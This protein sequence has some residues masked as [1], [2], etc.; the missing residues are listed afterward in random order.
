MPVSALQWKVLTTVSRIVSTARIAAR[1]PFVVRNWHTFLLS[2]FTHGESILRL[3]NG[4]KFAIRPNSS[5][6]ASI[7]EVFLLSG[8]SPVLPGSVVIDIGANIGAFS[9]FAAR[10]AKMIYSLEPVSNNFEALR[11]NVEM[12]Q[13]STVSIHRLAMA[14]NN[15]HATI[16]VAGVESSLYFQKPGSLT[17]LVQTVSLDR[18]LDDHDIAFVDYLKMDCEGAEWDILLNLPLHVFSRIKYIEL[19][20]HNIGSDTNVAVLQDRLA[21]ANFVSTATDGNR[22]N[23]KL[24]AF[25]NETPLKSAQQGA[26]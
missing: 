6:R 19:E 21:A 13:L 11:R 25:R 16:S 8:Y 1:L 17:E 26:A 22:F 3:R 4:L 5:D 2:R 12:N 18:F 23:G 20:F 10:S 15:T 9:L 14:S 7:S 24:I